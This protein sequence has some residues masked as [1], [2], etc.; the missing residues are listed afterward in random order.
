[1]TNVDAAKLPVM[2][3][4]LRL[5]TIGRLWQEFGARADREGWGSA[6]FLA[7]L[8][9]HELADRA[10]RRIARHMAES[11]LPHGKTFATFDFAAVPT[12]RRAHVMALAAGDTWLEQS[13]NLLIFGGSGTGKTHLAA[14]IG[15]ALVDNG[16]RVRSAALP[17][18]CKSYKQRG[19]IS[20]CRQSSPSS[21]AAR[22][23]YS[24]I[25]VTSERTKPRPASSSSSLPSAT[26][27]RAS[28]P[29]AISRSVSGTG[30]SPSRR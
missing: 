3:N 14:A 29:R 18:W 30:S 5:P 13:G 4:T 7:A 10:T 8:C 28:S 20:R 25:S 26:S 24:T 23:W 11:G 15:T 16:R 1:M 6:R 2:L 27:A 12:I 9:E 21:T 19:A 22:C 17:I